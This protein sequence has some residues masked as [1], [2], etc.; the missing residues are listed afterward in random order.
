MSE[1]IINDTTA[2]DLQNA[3][4]LA[5]AANLAYKDE[6]KIEK[7]VK[8]WGLQAVSF[9]DESGTQ[10]FVMSN[11]KIIVVAFR[12]TEEFEDWVADAR[13][14]SVDGPLQ[15][16]VHKGFYVALKNVWG[17]IKKSVEEWRTNNQQ[18]SLWF[19]G[20]SLGAA[21]AILAVAKLYDEKLCDEKYSVKGL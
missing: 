18:K 15:G 9:F 3:Y 16:Q 21:L 6:E 2:F 10:A 5:R 19:T 7:T 17:E 20:H 13:A 14:I 12:G 1:F 11:D 8:E 4:S